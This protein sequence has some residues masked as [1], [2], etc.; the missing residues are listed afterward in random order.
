MLPG[1]PLHDLPLTSPPLSPTVTT[2]MSTTP[3][4]TMTTA[5]VAEALESITMTSATQPLLGI[6]KT[7]RPTFRI[8]PQHDSALTVQADP[9]FWKTV[10]DDWADDFLFKAYVKQEKKRAL[11]TA[12]TP[13]S[14]QDTPLI[15]TPPSSSRAEMKTTTSRVGNATTPSP[16]AT[17]AP[18]CSPHALTLIKK[19]T[20]KPKFPQPKQRIRKIGWWRYVS[21]EEEGQRQTVEE[22][23]RRIAEG[24]MHL[25]PC[26]AQ[27]AVP[28]P[29]L[30]RASSATA[31]S[32][33]SHSTFPQP[34]DEVS[35]KPSGFNCIWG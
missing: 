20:K 15:Q 17:A 7:Q 1:M 6:W 27:H 22:E 25:G 28:Y 14:P 2:T 35:H 29:P 31:D 34:T 18:S 4:P 3:P 13:V 23:F 5:E 33:T 21:V 8:H 9:P 19:M 32:T 10:A 16:T 11:L 12:L 26:S 30:P 24:C